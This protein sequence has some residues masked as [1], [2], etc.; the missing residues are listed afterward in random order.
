MRTRIRP[1]LS[2]IVLLG[3]LLPGLSFGAL[4]Q[5]ATPT[6]AV[7]S[8]YTPPVPIPEGDLSE[9][10]LRAQLIASKQTSCADLELI[11]GILVSSGV[12]PQVPPM[13][14]ALTG[15]PID[16][17]EARETGACQEV[18]GAMPDTEKSTVAL[19]NEAATAQWLVQIHLGAMDHVMMQNPTYR[20]IAAEGCFAAFFEMHNLNIEAMRQAYLALVSDPT[21]EEGKALAS[22]FTDVLA[23]H[24]RA[25]DATMWDLARSLGDPNLTRSADLVEA[26]HQT[27]DKGIAAYLETLAAV[28]AGEAEPSAL[29]PL[30]ED[31][32][33]RTELHFGKEEITVVRPMQER[34][35]SEEFKP[36]IDEFDREIGGWLRDRGWSTADCS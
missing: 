22:F 5:E 26:E 20:P 21:V 29:V 34:M 6:A 36:V 4:A 13:I 25:E 2:L 33:I 24:A 11:A 1:L 35:S 14:S 18:G 8:R 23:P 28:E 7:S 31:V 10:A 12:L 30:A 27:I 3:L 16:E 9:D 19:M 17:L 32:R 15:M